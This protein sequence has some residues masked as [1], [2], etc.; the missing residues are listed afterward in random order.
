LF[1]GVCYEFRA[2]PNGLSCSP[3]LFTKILKLVFSTL[4]KTGH[5]NAI[6]ID[7]SFLTTETYNECEE[8]ILDILKLIVNLGF[9]IHSDK[10]ILKPTQ[11]ISFVGFWLNSVDMTIKLTPEKCESIKSCCHSALIKG[12]NYDYKRICKSNR[13]IGRKRTR[14][15]V[16]GAL[17]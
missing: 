11:D 8:N 1:K 6:Y 4:R 9:T 3:R 5:V 7:D 15:T 10:S 14:N 13:K 16:C 12:N 17:L 2:L